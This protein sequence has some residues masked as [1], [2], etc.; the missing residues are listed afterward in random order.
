[1]N[2]NL[3]LTMSVIMVGV[4]LISINYSAI[5][6]FYIYSVPLN[7]A[8]IIPN[9]TLKPNEFQDVHDDKDSTCYTTPSMNQYCYEKPKIHD[10][11]NRGHLTSFITGNNGINGELHFDKVG[12]EGGI[13]TIKNMEMIGKNTALFTFADND[14][15]VG[16]K[17]RTTYEITDKFEFHTIIE[18]YDTF[19]AKCNNYEGTSVTIVQYLGVDT[20]DGIDYFLTWHTLANSEQGVTCDYPQIVQHSFGHNFGL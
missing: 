19:I 3:L 1:M 12:L 7:K 13:F 20:I 15:R 16:N 4:I 17:D 11:Q 18:K 5:V 2:S 14:Y 8:T 9:F 10:S 6:D